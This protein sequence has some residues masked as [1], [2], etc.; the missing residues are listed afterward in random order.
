ML[1]HIITMNIRCF[2]KAFILKLT[3]LKFEGFNLIGSKVLQ[4][5]VELWYLDI[6][7][8]PHN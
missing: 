8:T 3:D 1:L 6:I 7:V 4:K 5:F 2:Y